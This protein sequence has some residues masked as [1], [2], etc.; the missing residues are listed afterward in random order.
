MTV[1]PSVRTDSTGGGGKPQ[2]NPTG[3]RECHLFL[4]GNRPVLLGNGFFLAG[5]RMTIVTFE[6]Q[7]SLKA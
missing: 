2:G 5:K 7:V 1:H 6:K 3:G 4:A